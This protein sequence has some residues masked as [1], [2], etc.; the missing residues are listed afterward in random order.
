MN[1]KQAI[2]YCKRGPEVLFLLEGEVTAYESYSLLQHLQPLIT[3]GTLTTVFLDMSQVSF[4][5]STT[6]G[7][8]I[9]LH[10]QL[11]ARGGNFYLCNL[12]PEIREI[13]RQLHLTEFF[14]LLELEEGDSLR[15]STVE[16]LPVAEKSSISEQFVFNMH[17]GIVDAAPELE[18]DFAP[19]FSLLKERLHRNEQKSD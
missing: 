6:I 15:Q 4:L 16:K 2:Y 7:T 18:A 3:S 13:V 8:F 1:H 10:E 11:A 5:D 14:Q 17:R 19:F 9:N 12:R